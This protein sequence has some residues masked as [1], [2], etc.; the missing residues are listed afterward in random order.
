MILHDLMKTD[1]RA[2]T[3]Q[4]SLGSASWTHEHVYALYKLA[5]NLEEPFRSSVRNRLASVLKFRGQAVPRINQPL[6]VP[7]LA[8][9]KFPAFATQWLRQVR[10]DFQH[11]LLPFH[12]PSKTVVEGRHQTVAKLL[13]SFREWFGRFEKSPQTSFCKCRH[14]LEEHPDLDMIDGHVA[15]PAVKLRMSSHL[16]KLVG[17]SAGSMVFSSKGTY[18]NMS[19]KNVKKWLMCI[20]SQSKRY[21][22]YGGFSWSNSG[23]C[24][25]K[26][27]EI[28]SHSRMFA[29]CASTWRAWCAI[30]VIMHIN[31]S[32]YSVRRLRTVLCMRSCH[33][34]HKPTNKVMSKGFRPCF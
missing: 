34:C 21:A 2:W 17:G 15:S 12:L 6:V 33:F 27:L 22:N 3:M 11:V 28:G 19:S 5:A 20:D 24:M 23:P 25:Y 31:K 26:C 29:G 32:W 18:L 9:S 4:R 14:V 16:L 1:G 30:I 10:N 13:L 7:F 8:H